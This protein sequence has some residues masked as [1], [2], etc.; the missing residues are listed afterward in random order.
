MPRL[1]LGSH[2]AGHGQSTRP[3]KEEELE[4]AGELPVAEFGADLNDELMKFDAPL[5][6]DLEVRRQPGNLLVTGTLERR[7]P[8][9]ALA[10]LALPDSPPD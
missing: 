7:W 10:C 1:G 2:H 4:L 8:A 6:Y 3:R 5:R 9:N